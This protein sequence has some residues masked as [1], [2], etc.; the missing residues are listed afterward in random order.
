MRSRSALQLIPRQLM[1]RMWPWRRVHRVVPLIWLSCCGTDGGATGDV[2]PRTA[3]PTLGAH[4]LAFKRDGQADPNVTT[5]AMTTTSIGSVLV[6]CVGRGVVTAHAATVDNKG[7]AY[8]PIGT[9]RT[10][11][12]FPNSGTACYVA[13]SVAGGTGHTVS[14]PISSTA[15]FDETTLSVV[16]VRNAS[17]IQDASW[18]EDL[19]APNTSRSVTT[20]GPATLIA[21]WWGDAGVGTAHA[22]APGN[23]FQLIHSLLTDAA[24]VQVAVATRDVDRAGTYD[25]TW[26][27][28]QGAQL[29]L[30]AVGK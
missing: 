28:N 23:G 27:S 24:L 11:T 16:E 17:R 14:A 8:T 21:V 2:V 5:A 3:T 13:A 12:T 1:T 19:T 20:T 6:S 4:A 10:Y 9:P 18:T 26:T 15:P 30:I 7:N 29:Y 25:I 22:A